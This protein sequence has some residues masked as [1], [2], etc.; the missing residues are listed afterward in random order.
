MKRYLNKSNELVT[1]VFEE[2]DAQFLFRGQKIETDRKVKEIRGDCT[3]I[4][5][6]EKPAYKTRKRAKS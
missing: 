4:D 3:I 2:G 1:I 5:L 6:P